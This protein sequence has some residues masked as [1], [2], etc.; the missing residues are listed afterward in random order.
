MA[1]I[2]HR[3]MQNSCSSTENLQVSAVEY[4]NML[5][6]H[7]YCCDHWEDDNIFRIH[8]VKNIAASMSDIDHIQRFCVA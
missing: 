2:N 3:M 4:Q 7:M 8:S 6:L 5:C 1:N